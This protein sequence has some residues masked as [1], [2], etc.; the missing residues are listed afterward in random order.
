MADV[1]EEHGL[2]PVEFGQ[3]FG[4]ALLGGITAGTRDAGRDVSGHQSDKCAVVLV[5]GPVPVQ[6]GHQKPDRGAALGDQRS[7]HG[8]GWWF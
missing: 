1:G 2:G 3:F 8:L 5:E 7:E 4:A 6:A